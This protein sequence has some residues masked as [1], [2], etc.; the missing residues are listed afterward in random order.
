[1]TETSRVIRTR[2]L[3]DRLGLSRTTLH[4]LRE[5]GDFPEPIRLGPNSVG[6][7]SGDIEAWLESRRESAPPLR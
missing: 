4:R 3:C 1:M 6:W 2:D 7:I 5:R